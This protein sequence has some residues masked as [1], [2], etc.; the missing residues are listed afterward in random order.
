MS[1][2]IYICYKYKIVIFLEIRR[3]NQ[4]QRVIWIYKI[5]IFQIEGINFENWM[6]LNYNVNN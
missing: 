4:K 3:F 2:F 6:C 5:K 1:E